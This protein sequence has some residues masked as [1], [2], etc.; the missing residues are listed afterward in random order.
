MYIGMY[1]MRIMIEQHSIADAR[2]N[3]PDLVKKAEAGKAVELTRRG[4]PVAGLIGRK[5]YE[6]LVARSRRF[7]DA[8]DEFAS[9]AGLAGL[10]I[11]PDGGFAEVREGA[12]RREAQ[13]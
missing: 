4:E 10:D 2:S 6:R 8:W 5:Q 3:L 13:L 7:S 11:D 12:P 1:V 9:E